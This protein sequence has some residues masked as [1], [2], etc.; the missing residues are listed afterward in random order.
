MKQAKS[1]RRTKIVCTIG[2][3]SE[4]PETIRALITA[5]MDVARLNFSHGTLE[6]QGRRIDTL[7]AEAARL[8]KNL[9]ILLDIQGPKIRLGHF[10]QPVL[11]EPGDTVVLT[12]EPVPCTR[13][14]ISVGYPHLA[15]DL[16]PGAPVFI[17][18]G[19]IELQVQKVAGNDV[20]C[21]V[22]VGGELRSRKGVS[23][24]GV[25][26][27]LPPA[28]EEDVQHL[29]F[30]VEKGVDYVAAS[31]VRRRS[32]VEAIRQIVREAGGDQPI[33]AKIESGEGVRR[34]DEIVAAADGVMVA[35]GDLGVETPLEEVPLVQRMIIE[36]CNEAGKPVITAT[37]ML[38]SMVENHRPTRAEVTD[39]AHAIFDGT[40][41]VM[42]S[43][44]TAV[45]R[46]P[47]EA[48]R[49]MAR[50]CQRIE[51]SLPY[52]EMLEKKRIYARRDIAEAISYATC[53]TASDLNAAAIL[54]ST[55][56]GSTARMVA[57]YRPRAPII[58]VTPNPAIVRRLA[59]V[60]GVHPLLVSKAENIDRMLDV[61]VGAARAAG[62]VTD[63]DLIAITAGVRTGVPG[64]TNLL[65]VVQVGKDGR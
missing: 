9:A 48:V 13:E 39:V 42:L 43:G 36:K 14:R 1:V 10:A 35:R 59:L 15:R 32:H 57:K 38:E 50:I 54:S 11:V 51:A 29:R 63:G 23:L 20:I 64:S 40:D 46:F 58:A 8:G 31:F 52:E 7:R 55:Q 62:L 18:D 22:Q 49:V 4:S 17:D 33:I 21:Q 3:A 27:D 16:R 6:E 12:S 25:E 41:A 5:G 28:T 60:W 47:V 44:E 56:S 37:Q 61:A 34:L 24:P 65:Q 2:P 26:I 45:G 30:G 19:L 53:Q